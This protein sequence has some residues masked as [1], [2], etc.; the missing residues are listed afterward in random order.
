M[1]HILP[2]LIALLT[3]NSLSQAQTYLFF[4]LEPEHF[5]DSTCKKPIRKLTKGECVLVE[6]LLPYK[7]KYIYAHCI[8]DGKAGFIDRAHLKLEKTYFPDSLGEHPIEVVKKEYHRPYV[9]FVNSSKSKISITIHATTYLLAPGKSEEF[10]GKPGKHRYKV[11][12]PG[13][14]PLYAQDHFQ[15]H[16]IHEIEFY[17]E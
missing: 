10:W 3:F 12:M 4:A 2:P 5:L 7:K 14:Q 17:M 9:R 13:Y 6:N 11:T 1:K 16:H 15:P 8:K